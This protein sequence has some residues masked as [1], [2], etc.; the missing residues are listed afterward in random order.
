VKHR[1]SR[2]FW[3][4]YQALPAE[5]RRLADENYALLKA[6]PNHPSLQFKKIGRY[7]SVRVGLHYRALAIEANENL[8]WFWI[9]HHSEYDRLVDS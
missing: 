7:R 5:V 4:C 2:R 9:G 8:I 3:T 6:N 1:A